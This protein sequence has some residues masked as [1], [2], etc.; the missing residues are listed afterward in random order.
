[1]NH[2]TSFTSGFRILLLLALLFVPMIAVA[3]HA[4]QDDLA[5]LRASM[6]A[7]YPRIL[8]LK[9]EGRLGETFDGRL[10]AL[11]EALARDAQIA[12]IIQEENADRKRLY[13]LLAADLRKNAK[14]EDRDRI[15]AQLVARRN[16]RRNLENAK[17]VEYF[18]VGPDVWLY[19]QNEERFL[20]IE[21]LKQERIVGET[22]EGLVAA[23]TDGQL[24]ASARKLLEEE[25]EWR[26]EFYKASAERR[27]VD[28]RVVQEE[29]GTARMKVE[30]G[31]AMIRD[32]DRGWIEAGKL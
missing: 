29:S 17:P 30:S 18:M 32:K 26:D 1:M 10:A 3:S 12:K 27:K 11:D 15:T 31:K 13:E 7:R 19:K 21:E 6:E 22:W 4:E 24:S 5:G 2:N 23:V 8:E 16:G 20:A 9:R 28:V 25:N 14:P